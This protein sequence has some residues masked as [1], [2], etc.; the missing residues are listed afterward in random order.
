MCLNIPKYILVSFPPSRPCTP[1]APAA[2]RLRSSARK[3]RASHVRDSESE[4]TEEDEGDEPPASKTG[5]SHIQGSELSE[6]D[7]ADTRPVPLRQQPPGPTA[8]HT[9]KHTALEV[10]SGA[11][12]RF[13]EVPG[14]KG[15]VARAKTKSS[16]PEKKKVTFPQ[17]HD[18]VTC[19]ISLFNY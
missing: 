10:K 2:Q 15:S 12:R 19:C 5:A 11:G 18:I 9:A 7:E 1:D 13:R 8:K 17:H 4:L 6:E 16:G 14:D 3:T